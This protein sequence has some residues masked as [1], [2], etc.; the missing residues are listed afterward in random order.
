MTQCV[1]RPRLLQMHYPV[2]SHAIAGR[3]TFKHAR[4]AILAYQED[5]N[6]DE[7]AGNARRL[8]FS[9]PRVLFVYNHVAR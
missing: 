7:P 8:L 4:A 9:G 3:C 1:S 5:R 2:V 6:D